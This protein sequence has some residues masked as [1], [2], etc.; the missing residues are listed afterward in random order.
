MAADSPCLCA[1]LRRVTRANPAAYDAA[2][3][4]VD[5]RITQFSILRILDRL[6]PVGV[7][8]LAAEAALDR[9]TMGRNLDPL[10]RRGFVRQSVNAADQ[11]ERVAALTDA[12]RAALSAAP[13]AV[14][15]SAG[16]RRERASAG[17]SSPTSPG[18]SP[19]SNPPDRRPE[20]MPFVRIDLPQASRRNTA[21]PS[22]TWSTRPCG[23]R[24][25]CRRTTVSK[26]SA[27][28]RRA[29]C[30][31]PD[32]SRDRAQRGR[33]DDPGDVER[34]AQRRTEESLLPRRRRR[35]AR[36]A[37][38]AARGRVH[39]PRRGAEGELVLRQR[40]GAIRLSAAS[41]PHAHPA[42]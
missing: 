41:D 10:E 19:G 26:S 9:S 12:G 16:A 6:G 23:R 13:A 32:L 5:L 38:A 31:R 42:S 24:S 39:Q 20:T 3:A 28:M 11:R 34:R 14:A 37:R 27:S 4:A 22:A 7:T 25:T 15:R 33:P 1:N 21:G 36:A 18:G 40:R 8:R 35:P 2:F 29:A 17:P 30:H